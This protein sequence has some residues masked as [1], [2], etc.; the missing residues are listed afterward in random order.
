MSQVLERHH[1]SGLAI[2]AVLL[3]L[4]GWSAAF[5]QATGVSVE[6][7]TAAINRILSDYRD[8]QMKLDPEAASLAGDRRYNDQLSDFSASAANARLSRGQTYIQ[9][10]SEIDMTGLPEKTRQDEDSL[11]NKLIDEQAG[12]H[13]RSWQRP[14][15]QFSRFH[16]Q[17]LAIAGKFQFQSAKDYDDYLARLK[18]I[19]NALSQIMTNIQLGAESGHM[20]TQESVDKVMAEVQAVT[21]QPAETSPFA[22]PLKRFPA[23]VP[24][25]DRKR[26]TSGCAGCDLNGGDPGLSAVRP[27]CYGLLRAKDGFSLTRTAEDLVAML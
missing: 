6:A 22:A 2:V 19:P 8:D 26:M 23:A 24:P 11:L 4:V 15:D 27:F 5:A 9:R 7:R 10:L 20:L 16:P 17:L 12:D 14:L 3:S 1:I 13:A 25:E 21:A 18:K